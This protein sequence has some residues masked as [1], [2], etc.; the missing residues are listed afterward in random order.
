MLTIRV[1]GPLEVVRDGAA[2]SLPQSKKTRALLG[3]LALSDRPPRRDRLIAMFWEVPDDPRGA[4]RWSLSKLRPIVDEPE[5]KRIDADREVV[6]FDREGLEI[7]FFAMRDLVAEGLE[8]QP[9]ARLEAA[10]AAFRGELLEGLDLSDC[11]DFGIWLAAM[12]EE[13]RALRQNILKALVHKLKDTPETAL[14]HARTLVEVDPVDF[15]ARESVMRLLA[16]LGRRNEAKQHYKIGS[17]LLEEQGLPGGEA[18]RRIWKELRGPVEETPPPAGADV[19]PSPISA[20]AGGAAGIMERPVVAVLP[21]DNLSQDNAQ[22]YLADGITEDVIT[23]LSQWRLFPVIARNS[24]FAYKGRP[25]DVVAVGEELGARY[26]VEGSVRKMGDQVR[27][28]AQLIDARTG[29]H[30]WANRFDREI[31]DI[32]ALQDELTE[33]IVAQLGPELE[34]AEWQRA[35][36]KRPQ[37]M[38][39]WDLDLRA[40]F[41]VYRADAGDFDEAR[42]LLDESLR[43]DAGWSQTY[44]I[45][46]YCEWHS[47]LLE[48]TKNPK[49]SADAYLAPAETAVRLDDSNWLGHAL[50]GISVL[51]S[52]RDYEAAE[53]EVARA[54]ALN[55]SAALAHQFQ[56]CV[57]SFAGEVA[58]AIAHLETALRLNPHRESA[59]LLLGDLALCHLQQGTYEDAVSYARQA[60]QRF[61]GNVRARQRLAARLGQLGRFGEARDELESLLKRQGTLS[62]RYVEVTYPFRNPAHMRTFLDGLRRAGWTGGEEKNAETPYEWV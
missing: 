2:L 10:A 7:D 37:T 32:F 6:A 33:H 29:I 8:T 18:L 31:R 51:W 23:A 26:V 48:W 59:T 61:G 5:R 4:L 58:R 41:H 35:E 25:M 1:L 19:R 44:A 38:D 52:R 14:L 55:P 57:L 54:I 30:I 12:R 50:L 17:K 9:I 34:R 43:L 11:P 56:G 53:R 22:D 47:I 13:A 39:A 24:T 42:R 20:S 3:Y 40:L 45:R 46:A 15:A 16:A 60:I 21:F 36:R 28:N 49:R 62:R 27:V